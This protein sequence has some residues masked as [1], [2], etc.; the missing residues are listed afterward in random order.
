MEMAFYGKLETKHM[1]ERISSSQALATIRARRKPTHMKKKKE[2]LRY[3]CIKSQSQVVYISVE[4][5][6][7][8]NNL[9]ELFWND[10][11]NTLMIFYISVCR[12]IWFH[13]FHYLVS[14]RYCYGAF[15]RIY[16]TNIFKKH[17][18]HLSDFITYKRHCR[19]S[20]KY[21]SD[22]LCHIFL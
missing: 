22:H 2:K 16:F 14:F 3:L 19:F 12:F 7:S 10:V 18:S 21:G 11:D 1:S 9:L 5:F 4:S 17:S 6:F 20:S 8:V 13:L 15:S